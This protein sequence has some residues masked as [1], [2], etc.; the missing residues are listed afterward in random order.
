GIASVNEFADVVA[1]GFHAQGSHLPGQ[2]PQL[3]FDFRLGHGGE[4]RFGPPPR[5]DGSRVFDEWGKVDQVAGPEGHPANGSDGGAG[6]GF[7]G[8]RAAPTPQGDGP[9]PPAGVLEGGPEGVV[10]P[11]RS[12]LVEKPQ[13]LAVPRFLA[14]ARPLEAQLPQAPPAGNGPPLA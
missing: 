7:P 4:L 5:V 12:R 8:P 14:D 3:G 1:G 9:H 13:K 10:S 11:W 2:A 6:V